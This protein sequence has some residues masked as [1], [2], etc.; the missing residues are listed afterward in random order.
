MQVQQRTEQE[1]RSDKDLIRSFLA[2][3]LTNLDRLVNYF[4][5]V[6]ETQIQLQSERSLQRLILSP[7]DFDRGLVASPDLP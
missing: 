4:C 1:Y 7:S 2:E 3:I 6:A 5:S